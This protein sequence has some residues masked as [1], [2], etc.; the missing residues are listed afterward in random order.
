MIF[1]IIPFAAAHEKEKWMP[2]PETGVICVLGVVFSFLICLICYLYFCMV[3]LFCCKRKNIKATDIE[4]IASLSKK[5]Y[6]SKDITKSST[7]EEL[8]ISNEI[9]PRDIQ[10]GSDLQYFNPE[11]LDDGFKSL[12]NCSHYKLMIRFDQEKNVADA[13]IL[14]KSLNKAYK[15]ETIEINEY[16]SKIENCHCNPN[17]R[18]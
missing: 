10:K 15:I 2:T 17:E 11:E 7:Y 9:D 6:A 16:L 5:P 1:Y 4:N 12:A 3:N 13:I 14:E 8:S 18:V